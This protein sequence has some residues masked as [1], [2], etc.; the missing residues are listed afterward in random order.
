M[1]KNRSS[2]NVS[3]GNLSSGLTAEEDRETCLACTCKHIAR[4]RAFACE[5]S[6]YPHHFFWGLGELSHAEDESG[7][8]YPALAAFIR[9]VRLQW[10]QDAAFKVPWNYMVDRV[11]EIMTHERTLPRNLK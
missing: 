11:I 1:G 5:I 10:Q 9:D 2:R 6:G 7:R 3:K 8:D 4:A